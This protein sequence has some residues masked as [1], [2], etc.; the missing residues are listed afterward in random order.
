[1]SKRWFI[2]F[3]IISFSAIGQNSKLSPEFYCEAQFHQ[4]EQVEPKIETIIEWAKKRTGKTFRIKNEIKGPLS[5]HYLLEETYQ[6]LPIF[7]STFKVNT[8]KKG[9]ILSTFNSTRTFESTQG[10]FPPHT[11]ISEFLNSLGNF[12][13]KLIEEE[14]GYFVHN[15]EL[16]RC[17]RIQHTDENNQYRETI[18]DQEGQVLYSNDL[19][20]YFQES[21]KLEIDTPCTGNI[22]FPDPLTSSGNSYGGP[23]VDNSN[24]NS[25]ELSS[26]L[27]SKQVTAHQSTALQPR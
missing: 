14:N 21:V 26:Q 3:T 10:D 11:A 22:Y 24:N 13:W 27:V 5:L 20:V 12:P 4:L 1:M 9:Q 23:W 19:L 6:G 2:L 15:S 18:L 17:K 16:I 8:T 7:F 25:I